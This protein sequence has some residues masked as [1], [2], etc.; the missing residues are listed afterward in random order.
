MGGG[1]H[2]AT[3]RRSRGGHLEEHREIFRDPTEEFVGFDVV[4]DYAHTIHYGWHASKR[5][6]DHVL[7]RCL[8]D[9]AD[10]T[11]VV[12][13]LIPTRLP[14]VELFAQPDL[15]G[16]TLPARRVVWN[17]CEAVVDRDQLGKSCAHLHDLG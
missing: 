17:V 9:P 10:I 14:A 1:S 6:G 4:K 16:S 3:R 13:A 8:A 2:A 11:E 15:C 12:V 7:W 5:D